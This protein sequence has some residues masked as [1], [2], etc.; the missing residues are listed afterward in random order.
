MNVDWGSIVERQR[1][2]RPAVHEVPDRRTSLENDYIRAQLQPGSHY[3]IPVGRP[4]QAAGTETVQHFEVVD[5]QH[6]NSRIHT[7]PTVASADEVEETAALAVEIQ[8]QEPWTPPEDLEPGQA[9]DPNVL[10]V[11]YTGE[12]RWIVPSSMGDWKTWSERLQVY[13]TVEAS[14]IPG[15]IALRDPVTAVPP[16]NVLDDRCPTLKIIQHNLRKGWTAVRHRVRHTSLAIGDYDIE[17]AERWKGYHQC[18]AAL[19]RCLPLTGELPSRG[20]VAYYQLLLR[21]VPTTPDLPNKAYMLVLIADKIKK[22]TQARA[23]TTRRRHG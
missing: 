7:L 9:P 14:I 20:L 3:A 17:E 18:V 12:S 4:G 11:R 23:L 10:Q 13:K 21:G 16:Y 5:Y 15:C 8:P 2:P 6:S 22:R 1:D 19:P